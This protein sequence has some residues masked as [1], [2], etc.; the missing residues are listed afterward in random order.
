V[1]TKWLFPKQVD[2]NFHNIAYLL[3]I[4]TV[5]G[6]TLCLEVEQKSDASRWRGDFT[7]RCK[8]SGSSSCTSRVW[9][10]L[11]YKH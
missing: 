8:H 9:V 11:G 6:D 4:S 2:V 5:N 1:L 3:T 7:S 10:D